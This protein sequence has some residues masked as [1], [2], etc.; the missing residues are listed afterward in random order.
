MCVNC[1]YHTPDVQDIM[2]SNT[3]PHILMG[4]WLA[5]SYG[6]FS[7]ASIKTK[8]SYHTL[9]AQERIKI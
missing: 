1:I 8:V 2:V 3:V 6:L 7:P 9:L 4:S 5:G